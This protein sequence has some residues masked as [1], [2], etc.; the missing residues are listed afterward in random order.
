MNTNYHSFISLVK[1]F[2]GGIEIPTL[3]RDYAQGRIN[4]QNVRSEFLDKLIDCLNTKKDSENSIIVLD[5]VYGYSER[6]KDKSRF[7]PLDGQQRLTTLFLLHL[8]CVQNESDDFFL[9]SQVLSY[10]TRLSSQKFCKA[11]LKATS[12]LNRNGHFVEQIMDA[13]WFSNSWLKDPT[14]K[15]MLVMLDDIDKR[16]YRKQ[17]SQYWIRLNDDQCIQFLIKDVNDKDNYVASDNLYIKMNARGRALTEF[18]NFKSFIDGLVQK[19]DS[20]LYKVWI[21]AIDHKWTDLFWRNRNTTDKNPEEIGDEF[22]RFFKVMLYDNLL[23][24]SDNQ[25]IENLPKNIFDENKIIDDVL[26]SFFNLYNL[27][28]NK[29]KLGESIYSNLLKKLSNDDLIHNLV[30]KNLNLFNKGLLDKIVNVLNRLSEKLD[31]VLKETINFEFNISSQQVENESP[32]KR[33]IFQGV[34]TGKVTFQNRLLFFALCETLMTECD[35]EEIKQKLRI[36]RNLIENRAYNNV[37][38]YREGLVEIRKIIGFKNVLNSFSDLS[39]TIVHFEKVQIEEER[40][41]ARLLISPN[42][43][44]WQDAVFVAENNE[45]L[46]GQISYLLTFSEIVD[47]DNP[48]N[49]N[50]ELFEKYRDIS[51][52]IFEYNKDNNSTCYLQRALLC[53]GDYSVKFGSKRKSLL[54]TTKDRDTTFKKLLLDDNSGYFKQLLDEVSL[55]DNVENGLISIIKKYKDSIYDYRKEL[56]YN[57]NL[58]RN[59]GNYKLIEESS[60][61]NSI[62][63]LITGRNN[64]WNIAESR[65]YSLYQNYISGN[66]L[67]TIDKSKWSIRYFNSVDQNVASC[68]VI[69]LNNNIGNISIDIHF[70]NFALLGCKYRISIFCRNQEYNNNSGCQI[71]SNLFSDKLEKYLWIDNQELKYFRFERFMDNEIDCIENLMLLLTD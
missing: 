34:I 61:K 55:V 58:L 21:D 66:C 15:G 53:Y 31:L 46:L 29:Q 1:E 8:Y 49:T 17:L 45:Y 14:I 25:F 13:S 42:K 38:E 7:I 24:L 27:E 16:L 71:L 36:V 2:S 33:N 54:N 51:I 19:S 28:D 69:E 37:N 22:M 43:I 39:N 41:K 11:I 40:N 62:V 10:N 9:N 47:F 3:Q 52:K 64:G 44:Q 6:D 30:F 59:I 56:I 32:F 67:N 23:L 57:D 35:L 5:F 48:T 20:E 63:Y 12:N 4:R 65:S 50:L 68:M 26:I 18:E 60:K 70:D